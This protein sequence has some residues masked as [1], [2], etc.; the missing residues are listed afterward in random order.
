MD[1]ALAS[2]TSRS[3]ERSVTQFKEFCEVKELDV[4]DGEPVE[5][6]IAHLIE[7]GVT[8]GTIRSRLSA[9]RHHSVRQR[10]PFKFN[11]P[12]VALLV[13]GAAKGKAKPPAPATH[14]NLKEDPC[15]KRPLQTCRYGYTGIFW[16][17]ATI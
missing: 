17:L 2:S 12:K 13:K 6:W 16:I 15:K 8:H 7:K 5:L 14:Q 3:Y 9:F 11:S 1:L 10:L 4:R